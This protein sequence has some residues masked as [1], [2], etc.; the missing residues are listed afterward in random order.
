MAKLRGAT[1]EDLLK[2][3]TARYNS[4]DSEFTQYKSAM[5]EI[6]KVALPY[7]GRYLDGQ[8]DKYDEGKNRED[9]RTNST[10][11]N[12]VK[13]SSSAIQDGL[14]SSSRPFWMPMV[15]DEAVGSRTDVYAWATR[16]RNIVSLAMDKS[17]FYETLANVMLEGFVFGTGIIY[18]W[19]DMETIARAEAD[20]VGEYRLARNEKGEI[21]AVYREKWYTAESMERLWGRENLTDAVI[22]ALDR[23]LPY[24]K[25]LVVQ[26]IEPARFYNKSKKGA[27][28]AEY[29]SV[30]FMKDGTTRN[31][32]PLFRKHFNTKPFVV[33]RF[34]VIAGNT[35]G[36]SL[37][38]E[39]LGE[40]RYLQDQAI[41]LASSIETQVSPTIAAPADM[42]GLGQRLG[43]EKVVY[44][45]S[46]NQAASIKPVQE[47]FVNIQMLDAVIQ[48]I[49]ER[50]REVLLNNALKAITNIT[51]EA[52]RYE[53][54]KVVEEKMQILSGFVHRFNN[55]FLRGVINRYWG[56]C[57]ELGLLEPAPAVLSE[58]AEL[59]I[60]FTSLLALAQRSIGASIIEQG[61]QFT[62][63]AAQADQGVLDVASLENHVRQYYRAISAPPSILREEGEVEKLRE[64]RQADQEQQMQMENAESIA[65]A[66]SVA[67]QT[68]PNKDSV[69]SK[70][71]AGL[72][73][74]SK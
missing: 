28:A 37:V 59:K 26:A 12:A 74:A 40:L 62:L 33:N 10:V 15:Y 11:Y 54:T 67:N 51:K 63:S 25:F 14:A 64:K 6:Q 21:D 69:L 72:A 66:A 39:V 41:E 38:R 1:D 8:S 55:E 4:L 71:S 70:L 56:I 9:R 45:N 43:K 29:E 16:Q 53:I 44:Y 65:N 48:R 61:L 30:Y 68:I 31:G 19:E 47:T 22:S 46:P 17:G 58:G 52:T 23:N 13:V 7:H 36:Q 50:I 2:K 57:E 49:E 27:E 32:K 3:V 73:G 60:E 34:D 42:K 20:T 18:I 24:E 5:S 35:Y